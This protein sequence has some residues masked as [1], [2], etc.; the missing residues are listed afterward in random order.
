[1]YGC[2][3]RAVM[4]IP[5]FK[6]EACEK[7]NLIPYRAYKKFLRKNIIFHFVFGVNSS[8]ILMIVFPLCLLSKFCL[9]L[10]SHDQQFIFDMLSCISAF[11]LW[12]LTLNMFLFSVDKPFT[13]YMSLCPFVFTWTNLLITSSVFFFSDVYYTWS[14][15]FVFTRKTSDILYVIF[16]LCFDTITGDCKDTRSRCEQLA[17]NN[18]CSN[19]RVRKNCPKSCN[20]CCKWT[21]SVFFSL[22]KIS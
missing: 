13:Y 16:S 3:L 5:W 4:P 11:V 1:M 12:K 21:S 2:V 19:K 6:I 9:C 15:L 18:R 10:L 8:F 20:V 14:S 17:K 22:I 7:W